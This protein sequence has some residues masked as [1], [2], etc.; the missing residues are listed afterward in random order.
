MRQ[1][2]LKA[3]QFIR[4]NP[5]IIYSLVLAVILPA[6]FFIN[7]YLINSSYEK[8]ID[9][10]T[11]SK[12]VL[13]ENI[14]NVLIR[15][16][17]ADLG[18]LQPIIET[19][20]R[21]NPGIAAMSIVVPEDGTGA[22]KT[23]ASND[24]SAVGRTAS[25][26]IQNMI[27]WNKPEGVAF[28]DRNERGRFWN[29]TKSLSD[30]SGNRTALISMAFALDDSDALVQKTISDSYWILLVIIVAVV[31]LV[32]NQ[33]RL[34]GYAVSVA[35]LKEID[36]MKDM[37]IS[38]AS[39]ELRTPLTAVRGYVNLLEESIVSGPSPENGKYLGQIK[40]SV[41]RLEDL[42]NDVLEVSRV[43]GNRLP[44]NIVDMDPNPTIAESVEEMR[45]QA[46]KKGLVLDYR[47]PDEPSLISADKDR[48]KQVLV[49][50]VGNAVKYTETGTV[51][52]S[53]KTHNDEFLI[54]VADTGMGMSAEDQ[55][56]LFQK[57]YRIQNEKTRSIIGTG[58][59]LW[60]TMEIVKKMR[61]RIAVESIEGIG[62]HFTVHLPIAKRP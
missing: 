34:F 37:F 50:L 4:E 20:V 49:N 11:Q 1:I 42:V 12:A 55:E 25:D 39:H 33:G 61:G 60:I 54:T 41:Q 56:K 47:S 45:N 32:A 43:E 46:E 44:M 59:G 28:L 16:S 52:V 31:L 14:I 21:E 7:T 8:N 2:F 13:T 29:V 6:S 48:L 24:A 35:K 10:I 27:A 23:V 9:K 5:R 53:A 19:I 15:D 30:G 40:L 38:M 17:L 3:L 62:S 51:T 58:L 36:R 22:F 57:F 18:R 26:S